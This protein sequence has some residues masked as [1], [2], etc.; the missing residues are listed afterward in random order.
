MN[1]LLKTIYFCFSLL[2]LTNFLLTGCT[3]LGQESFSSK[4][5]EG[6]GWKSMQENHQMIHQAGDSFR[7]QHSNLLPL[8]TTPPP[9]LVQTGPLATVQR[10]PEQAIRVWFAPYQDG[11]GNLHEESAMHTVVQS[12]QWTVPSFSLDDQPLA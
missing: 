3:S 2:C 6:F 9:Y 5:G 7:G 4:P 11:S 8:T 12:G 10:S 1:Y